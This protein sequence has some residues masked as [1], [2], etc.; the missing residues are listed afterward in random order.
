VIAVVVIVIYCVLK[1]K[2]KAG[3]ISDKND[4]DKNRVDG[5]YADYE[6]MEEAS[7]NAHYQQLEFKRK[8]DD[9]GIRPANDSNTPC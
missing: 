6:E 5:N 1:K 8:P 2:R 7:P 3:P 9:E 4:S